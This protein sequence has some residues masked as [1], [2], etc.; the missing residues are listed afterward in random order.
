MDCSNCA[1]SGNESNEGVCAGCYRS[2]GI[3]DMWEPF[4]NARTMDVDYIVEDIQD[5]GC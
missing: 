3:E 5:E 1:N 4:E 2:T